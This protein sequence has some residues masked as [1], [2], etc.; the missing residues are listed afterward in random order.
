MEILFAF[1]LH[2][3]VFCV[4]TCS[5]QQQ[6]FWRQEATLDVHTGN[7]RLNNTIFRHKNGNKISPLLS[8]NDG[9][10][11]TFFSIIAAAHI[12]HTFSSSSLPFFEKGK[13]AK[14]LN[15]SGGKIFHFSRVR[16]S[17]T[18]V[19]CCWLR[20]KI[21]DVQREKMMPCLR[22]RIRLCTV[23]KKQP[24]PALKMRNG[25]ILDSQPMLGCSLLVIMA[26]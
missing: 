20:F 8:S 1:N 3:I 25:W 4:C 6:R 9:D 19:F 12:A 11:F 17:T 5:N 14:I 10:D 24:R 18:A 23:A 26:I 15:H 22:N 16:S 21:I 2:N 7:C 13:K